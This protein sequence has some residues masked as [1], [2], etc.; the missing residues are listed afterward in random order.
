[1]DITLGPWKVAAPVDEALAV[2]MGDEAWTTVKNRPGFSPK[3]AEKGNPAKTG[4]TISGKIMSVAKKESSTE[5]FAVYT[6]WVNGTISNAAP[7]Q[8][9]AAVSGGS[10]AENGVRAVTERNINKL[11]EVIK[12]GKIKEAS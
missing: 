12:A 9:R 1:M 2:A 10:T 4:F 7:L 5:I 8:G 6:I 11:L 3:L